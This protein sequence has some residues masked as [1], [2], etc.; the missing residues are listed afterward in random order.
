M[1]SW[2]QLWVMH[3]GGHRSRTRDLLGGR[4]IDRLTQSPNF[5]TGFVTTEGSIDDIWTRSPL[6]S[7]AMTLN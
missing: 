7:T 3:L 5:K 6:V 1:C 2:A 4:V